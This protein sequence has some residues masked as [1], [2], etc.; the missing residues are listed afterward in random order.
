M[1]PVYNRVG[2]RTAAQEADRTATGFLDHKRPRVAALT[3][4]LSVSRLDDHLL[5]QPRNATPVPKLDARV[6]VADDPAGNARGAP[7][8]P[9]EH[10][11]PGLERLRGVRAD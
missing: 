10:V 7:D 4:R 11:L 6:G 2:A 8:L 3:K 5:A 9:H 1:D